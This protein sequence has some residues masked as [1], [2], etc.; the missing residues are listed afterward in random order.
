MELINWVRL[1]GQQAQGILLSLFPSLESQMCTATPGFLCGC[2]RSELRF[3]GLDDRYSINW[4]IFPVFIIFVLLTKHKAILEVPSLNC[5]HMKKFSD[6]VLCLIGYLVKNLREKNS[7]LPS[8]GLVIWR[9]WNPLG[10]WEVI[11]WLNRAGSYLV[12]C[13]GWFGL[14]W[15]TAG[16]QSWTV[17]PW[18][19]AAHQNRDL[20][21]SSRGSG[22]RAWRGILSFC[23]LCRKPKQ[24]KPSNWTMG[25]SSR[26]VY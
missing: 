17:V 14:W 9:L 3:S 13:H 1:A 19:G 6:D 4:A 24:G 10:C 11:S 16:W 18:R 20:F 2:R 5:E 21:L 12:H 7:S 22:W 8:D 23:D 26:E 15:I 25:F